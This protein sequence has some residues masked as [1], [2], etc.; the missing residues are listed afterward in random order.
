MFAVVL[1][2]VDGD[3]DTDGDVDLVDAGWF[4]VCFG[5][6]PTNECKAAFDFDASGAIDLADWADFVPLLDASGPPI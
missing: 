4:Q 3:Y 5:A 1:P 6:A 2:P